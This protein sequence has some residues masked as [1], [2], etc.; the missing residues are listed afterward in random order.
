MQAAGVIYVATNQ[1]N[2]KQYVGLTRI[3]VA[4]R[5][6]HHVTKSNAPKT[7]FHKA[8]AKHGAEAFTV[9][10][11]A[12]ALRIEDL[13]A[14]ECDVIKQLKPA[15]NQTNG[16]EVTLGRKYDNAALE[17]IRIKNT[18]KKRSPEA[19]ERNRAQKLAWF[20][21]H[22]EERE[23]SAIQLREARA[24]I[25]EAKRIAAVSAAHKNRV[26]SDESRAKLSASC[27]GRRYGPEVLAKMAA[28][29]R[30]KVLCIQT[31]AVYDCAESA[32][33]VISAHKA[34]VNAA[35]KHGRT[36]YGFNFK[37]VE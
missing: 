13:G 3:G 36:V 20:A 8:I 27:M 31:G 21:A 5:W 19:R 7:Y 10:T 26:W 14:L 1:A 17:R 33:A 28:T 18:G 4:R 22:P 9:V 12:S 16:G 24:L 30:R 6:S 32:A 2:G 25:D 15:Y 37:Y 29:K 34:S 11:Y 35:C 23:K